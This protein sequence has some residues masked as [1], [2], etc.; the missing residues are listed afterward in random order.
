[1]A[2]GPL[3]FPG[4]RRR[5]TAAHPF[6]A[7][8]HG[9]RRHSRRPLRAHGRTTKGIIRCLKRHIPDRST[10]CSQHP[11]ASQP[12]RL[13]DHRSFGKA[14][15]FNRT[16]RTDWAYATGWTSNDQR[17][18]ALDSWLKHYNTARSH[19]APGGRPPSAGSPSATVLGITANRCSPRGSSS[20]RSRPI[21]DAM[22]VEARAPVAPRA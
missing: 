18:A 13:D 17:T 15:R 3:H 4:A 20:A 2:G 19:S 22:P 9:H 11:S 7:H 5:V 6:R 1:M 14:E 16:V 12:R 10:N 8:A 21:V